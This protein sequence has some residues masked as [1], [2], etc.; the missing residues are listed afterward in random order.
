VLGF[1]W[2]MHAKEQDEIY[3]A[4]YQSGSFSLFYVGSGF[5]LPA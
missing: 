2:L 1:E 3:G 4:Q 5:S